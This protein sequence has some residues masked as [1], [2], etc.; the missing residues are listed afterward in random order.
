MLLATRLSVIEMKGPSSSILTGKQQS[1]KNIIY[2]WTLPSHTVAKILRIQIR[3][4]NCIMNAKTY[5][6]T[7]MGSDHNSVI[8]NMSYRLKHAKK[9]PLDKRVNIKRVDIK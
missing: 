8:V 5:P 2:M 1:I 6:G 7:D 9:K 3:Y 4:R